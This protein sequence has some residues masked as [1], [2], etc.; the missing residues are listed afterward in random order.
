M[1]IQVKTKKSL[2]MFQ[3]LF[4]KIN[5]IMENLMLLV[6][7]GLPLYLVIHVLIHLYK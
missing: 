7:V 3:K 6:V 4:N 1:T 2:I 5:G